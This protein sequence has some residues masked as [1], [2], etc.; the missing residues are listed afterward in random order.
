MR[1]FHHF[2]D[3]K[4]LKHVLD[5]V[6]AKGKNSRRGRPSRRATTKHATTATSPRA[7]NPEEEQE[8]ELPKVTL[9]EFLRREPVTAG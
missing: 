2:Y 4:E 9:E 8:F 3:P 7:L 6:T 5:A 1:A